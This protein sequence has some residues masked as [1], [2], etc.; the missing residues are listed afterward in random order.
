MT[1]H[2]T[3]HTSRSNGSQPTLHLGTLRRSI[4]RLIVGN[5]LFTA[6]EQLLASHN[7]HECED[8]AKLALWLKNVHRVADEREQV[9]EQADL[10]ELTEAPLVRYATA[11]QTSEIHRLTLHRTIT[12]GERTKALLALPRLNNPTATSLIGELWAKIL[13]RGGAT[14]TPTHFL[15][16]APLPASPP[17]VVPPTPPRPTCPAPFTD[18]ATCQAA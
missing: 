4:L 11:E 16:R 2:V 10:T 8:S 9:V 18:S 17:P 14:A 5:S 7:T 1:A 3:G 6:Q 12:P 13:H 15:P